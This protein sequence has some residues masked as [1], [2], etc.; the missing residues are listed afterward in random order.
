MPSAVFGVTACVH[1]G[2]SCIVRVYDGFYN[3]LGDDEIV[4]GGRE[5]EIGRGR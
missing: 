3:V 2:I 5:R 1:G 4:L